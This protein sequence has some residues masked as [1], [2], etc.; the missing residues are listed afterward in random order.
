MTGAELDWARSGIPFR[1]RFGTEEGERRAYF[2][3]AGPGTICNLTFLGPEQL[4]IFGTRELPPN[5]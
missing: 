3:E 5:P 2:T 4:S 1:V